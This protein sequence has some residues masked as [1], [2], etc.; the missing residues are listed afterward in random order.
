MAYTSGLT[1]FA[2]FIGPF[3]G[4]A[5]G[6]LGIFVPLYFTAAASGLALLLAFFFLKDSGEF[7]IRIQ[8]QIKKSKINN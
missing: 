5:I 4:S 8:E 6:E 2:F 1:S 3:I 7:K